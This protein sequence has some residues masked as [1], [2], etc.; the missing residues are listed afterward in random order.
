MRTIISDRSITPEDLRFNPPAFSEQELLAT[1]FEQFGERGTLAWLEGERD[2]NRRLTTPDG[3]EFVLKVSGALEDPAVVDFQIRALLHLEKLEPDLPV[4]RIHR[5]RGGEPA[6]QMLTGDGLRHAV[7]LVSYL[8]GIPFDGGPPPSLAGLRRVGAFQARVCRALGSFSHPAADHF[9]PWDISNGLVLSEP[10]WR[11]A[12]AD[13]VALGRAFTD[14]IERRVLPALADLRSQVVHNDTHRG[15]LL[16]PDPTSEEIVGLIDFGDMVC[17][18]LVADLAISIAGFVE[19][20]EDIIEAACALARGFHEVMPLAEDEIAL[21]HDLVVV[22]LV[23][24]LLLTDFQLA[25]LKAPPAFLREERPV[26]I[27]ALRRVGEIDRETMTRHYR[28]AC[29]RGRGPAEAET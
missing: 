12:R 25:A 29:G 24:A 9:M 20:R 6:G 11:H 1:A 21:L 4:P 5:T 19:E 15:N 7:R 23:L 2:Q 14:H 28:S 26:L 10:L 22:R 17:A 8:P 3:R 13:T 18:P 16:R 27:N